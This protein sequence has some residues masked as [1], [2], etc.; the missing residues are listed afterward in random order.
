MNKQDDTAS[1]IIAFEQGDMSEDEI[2]TFFQELV[3]QGLAWQMQGA[4]G[5]LAANLIA[6][7]LVRAATLQ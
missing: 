4:Y 6:H 2:I 3:D 1:K 5:R 7:G